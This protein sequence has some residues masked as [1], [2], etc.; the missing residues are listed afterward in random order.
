MKKEW[1]KP[2]MKVITDTKIILECLYEVY[3]M[4]GIAIAA[5]HRIE[6]TMVYPFVKMLE[7][8]YSNISA[9]E[10]HQK[11][12][13]FYMNSIDIEIKIGKLV[14]NRITSLGKGVQAQT[15]REF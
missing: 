4:D 8:Q 14:V 2:E 1:V 3:Q 10:I 15:Y 6:K 9:E 12:W 13:E 11:L 5:D 7:N